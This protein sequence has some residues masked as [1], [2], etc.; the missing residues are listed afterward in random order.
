MKKLV[1]REATLQSENFF[2]LSQIKKKRKK[3][4]NIPMDFLPQTKV[5]IF[6][7]RLSLQMRHEII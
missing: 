2:N 6:S 1:H 5:T 4:Y 3:D 7:A